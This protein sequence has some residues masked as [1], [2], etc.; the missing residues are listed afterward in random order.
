LLILFRIWFNVYGEDLLNRLWQTF[1]RNIGHLGLGHSLRNAQ[2]HRCR[3]T[4]MFPDF[5]LQ[6]SPELVEEV[7]AVV[8]QGAVGYTHKTVLALA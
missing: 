3:Q 8:A 4:E 6:E 1:A 5:A 7:A 2:T